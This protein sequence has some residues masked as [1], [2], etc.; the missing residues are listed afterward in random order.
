MAADLRQKQP[1]ERD[2][3]YLR[4]LRTQPCCVCHDN[5]ST[6]PHHLRVAS[7]NHD[8]RETGGGERASDKWALPLCSQCHR[9]CHAMNEMLFFTMHGIDPF[10][11]AMHYH[12]GRTSE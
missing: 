8:K 7:I 6:E 11:L 1:R 3:N 5:I 9:D 10:A 2:E 12:T 4:Y